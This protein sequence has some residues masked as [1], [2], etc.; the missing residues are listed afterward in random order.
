M[1]R[2]TKTKAELKAEYDIMLETL[3]RIA[4]YSIEDVPEEYKENFSYAYAF[5][6]LQGDAEFTLREVLGKEVL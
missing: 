3:R 2:K 6:C 5:G 1:A 4:A